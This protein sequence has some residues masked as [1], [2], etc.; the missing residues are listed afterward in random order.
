MIEALK[1]FVFEL[2]ALI[3]SV[4][5]SKIIQLTCIQFVFFLFYKYHQNLK[6]INFLFIQIIYYFLEI[7]K[8]IFHVAIRIKF[9][10]MP[11]NQILAIII[12]YLT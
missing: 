3:Y 8:I 6:I 7:L 11:T 4:F 9:E 5:A 2:L 12:S 1:Y 10:T